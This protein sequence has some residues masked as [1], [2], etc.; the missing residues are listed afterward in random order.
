M[1]VNVNID[2][3]VNVSVNVNVNVDVDVD[4][5]VDVNV[6]V[7]V[8]VDVNV[9]VDVVLKNGKSVKVEKWKSGFFPFDRYGLPYTLFGVPVAG[10]IVFANTGFM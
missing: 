5:N 7:D 10:E 1:N 6:D 2:V 9:D 8:D 4:V 3:G